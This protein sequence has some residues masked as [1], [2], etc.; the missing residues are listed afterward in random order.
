MLKYLTSHNYVK[1]TFLESFE[2]LSIGYVNVPKAI[3]ADF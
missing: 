2:M 1:S 3:V